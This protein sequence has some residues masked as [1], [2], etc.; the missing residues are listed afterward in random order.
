MKMNGVKLECPN[1][2]VLVLPRPVEDIIFKAK[3]VM[4]YDEFEKVC[5]EPKPQVRTIKGG[6]KQEMTNDAS[7][8]KAVGEHNQKRMCWIFL[9]S[10]QATPGL[11]WETVKYDDPNTWTNY[12]DELRASGFSAVEINRI[13]DA[14]MQANCLDEA[15]LESARK[16]FLAGQVQE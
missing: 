7:Y 4:D 13:N 5:P 15:K 3:A 14:V 2:V 1:E 16:A 10:L 11:E 12:V 8:L 6:V 9:K